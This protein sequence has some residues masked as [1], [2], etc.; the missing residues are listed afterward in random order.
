MRG[1]GRAGISPENLPVPPPAEHPFSPTLLAKAAGLAAR[2][3]RARGM[4]E[5]QQQQ[6]D[7]PGP[8]G[9]EHLHLHFL[10]N[11]LQVSPSEPG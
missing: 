3:P 10:C 4:G 11:V 5:M 2:P 9:P 7:P 6:R 8:G 1:A